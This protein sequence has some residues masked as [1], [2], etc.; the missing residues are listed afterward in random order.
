[1][2]RA[3][4]I[5][6]EETLAISSVMGAKGYLFINRISGPKLLRRWMLVTL[7]QN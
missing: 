6:T 3:S 5:F 1:M 2:E 4:L 7:E